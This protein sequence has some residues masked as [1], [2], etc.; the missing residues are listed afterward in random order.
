MVQPWRLNPTFIIYNMICILIMANGEIDYFTIIII[1]I[2]IIVGAQGLRMKLKGC[3]IG[4]RTEKE[5]KGLQ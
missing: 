1:I 2:I 4:P 5:V 3:D